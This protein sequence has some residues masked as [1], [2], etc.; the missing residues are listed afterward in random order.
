MK[1]M[2]TFKTIFTQ[3][4]LSMLILSFAGCKKDDDGVGTPGD[5]DSGTKVR[6]FKRITTDGSV[7][8]EDSSIYEYNA[9]GIL[10]RIIER[11]ISSSPP[12]DYDVQFSINYNNN[13][14]VQNLTFIDSDTGETGTI[15]FG[16]SE[17]RLSSLSSPKGDNIDIFYH[18]ATN[19]FTYQLDAE[20]AVDTIYFNSANDIVRHASSFTGTRQTTTNSNT[21]VF[22]GTP[23]NQELKIYFML[24]MDAVGL[25][26]F[27]HSR[28][29]TAIEISGETIFGPIE[30]PYILNVVNVTRNAEGR[31]TSYDYSDDFDDNMSFEITYTD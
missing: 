5:P 16:Y 13:G 9:N 28:E 14:T 11:H 19:A 25:D 22:S 24:G 3:L 7:L 1:N 4:F 2:K 23:V 12:A 29:I 15:N 18:P 26:S 21:G 17:G 30:E 20:L 31:I 6:E 8:K 10:S 27:F